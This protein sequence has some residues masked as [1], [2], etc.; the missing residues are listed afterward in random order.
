MAEADLTNIARASIATPS[1]GVVA[2]F[3]D[4]V[5]K[6]LWF[7][8]ETARQGPVGKSANVYDVTDY[9]LKGDDATDN[10]AAWNILYAL[11]PVNAVVYFPAGTYR[12]SAEL[13]LSSNLQLK[14]IGDGRSRSLLK[15]TS[16]TANLFNISNAAFYYSF[17]E[18][19]FRASVAKTA[20]AYIAAPNSNDY[21]DIRWC[22][23]QGHFNAISLTGTTAANVGIIDQCHFNSPSANGNSIIVNGSNINTIIS[24]C[25]I[26][27]A[28]VAGTTGLLINQSGAVQVYGCDFIGG[29]NAM[30]VNA[31]AT[32]SAVFVTNTFFDQSTLG[33]TVKFSGTFPISRVKF[34]QCGITCGIVGGAGVTACEIAGTGTGTSIPEAID[35]IG[36]DFYNNG[37]SG[38]TTGLLVTGCKGFTVKDCRIAGFTNGIN[39][40]PYNTAGFTTLNI[41]GNVIGA[42]EN[43]AANGTGI[44]LNAGGVAYG[45]IN[46]TGNQFISNTVDNITD[47]STITGQTQK[48]IADNIGDL[49]R[50]VL[51]S[52]VANTA[53]INTTE[54]IVTGG[55]NVA[56][57]PANS[58]VPGT[59]IKVTLE[60]TCTATVANIT[61]FKIR[62][63]ALGTATGDTAILTIATPASA[64]A[65][66]N[67]PFQVSILITIRT[68]GA[69]GTIYGVM[70]V[71]NQAGATVATA[72]TGIM[73]VPSQ[74]VIGTVAAINTTVASY[75]TVTCITAA[76]TTTNTFQQGLIEIIK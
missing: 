55:L 40:T 46:I 16:A 63:G 65:G 37:G 70:V 38:T 54:T 72:S 53:G 44:L 60:G 57:I 62:F 18:L 75:I 23:F 24:N 29:V 47:N 30:L 39:V 19:G 41:I 10:L 17:Q 51:A 69:A 73:V 61:T 43:F 2:Y 32:V 33:S 45:S 52:I 74:I 31:T 36:C 4:L 9:G 5:T 3:S 11:L 35:F 48:I 26:N 64:A 71:N 67:I 27:N 68:I 34:V 21:L 13:T 42:N 7:T 1:A 20:G 49:Y 25:T 12:F 50:G 28:V 58:L 22:E 8:D 14:I 59:T 15:T 6:R 56:P 76:T 66:T